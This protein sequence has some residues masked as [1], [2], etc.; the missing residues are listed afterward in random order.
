MGGLGAVEDRRAESSSVGQR[1]R[2]A[3]TGDSA[4]QCSGDSQRTSSAPSLVLGR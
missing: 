2:A 1:V 4:E 3:V